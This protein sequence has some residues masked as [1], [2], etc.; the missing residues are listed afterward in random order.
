MI[1]NFVFIATFIAPQS[2]LIYKNMWNQSNIPRWKAWFF[3]QKY[4]GRRTSYMSWKRLWKYRKRKRMQNWKHPFN[5]GTLV[6]D[7]FACWRNKA[8]G[9][10]GRLYIFSGQAAINDAIYSQTFWRKI[11]L[12]D[13]AEQAVVSKSTA[14]N[15]FRRYLHDTPVHYLLK[16]RLQESASLLVT[17]QKK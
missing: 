12:E 3:C 17:T 13:I 16:Y 8:R 5:S 15:L 14:L 2:S 1:P 9:K 4:R 6:F 7:I 11:S 10:K